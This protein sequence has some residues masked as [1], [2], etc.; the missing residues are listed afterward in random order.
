MKFNLIVSE[1]HNELI[2]GPSDIQ[3]GHYLA[4]YICKHSFPESSDGVSECSD[5]DSDEEN[6]EYTIYNDAKIL[7]NLLKINYAEIK[8]THLFIRNYHNIINKSSYFQPQIAE[9]IYI[10][11]ECTAIIK[12]F[13]LKIIQRTWKKVY[14]KRMYAIKLHKNPTNLFY[15]QMCGPTR[16]PSLRGMLAS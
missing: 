3:Y 10:G 1:L 11:D 2:H 9:C 8:P 12:T 5:I 7:S 4:S 14:A 16:F 13:W 15:R 6:V